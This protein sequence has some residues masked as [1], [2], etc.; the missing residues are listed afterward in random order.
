MSF[1]EIFA[2]VHCSFFAILFLF[3][4]SLCSFF[5]VMLT[6]W[7]I[8]CGCPFSTPCFLCSKGSVTK[9]SVMEQDW[10]RAI[11]FEWSQSRFQ[12]QNLK[13]SVALA[14]PKEG[15]KWKI[16]IVF[17]NLKRNFLLYFSFPL[18]YLTSLGWKN[19]LVLG[20][21]F[22]AYKFVCMKKYKCHFY[23]WSWSRSR[24]KMDRLRK[25]WAWKGDVISQPTW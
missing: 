15:K 8:P 4:Q 16:L 17:A 18:R 25:N 1:T 13:V 11:L 10:A 7:L 14:P 23:T 5:W 3:L 20:D 12:S 9:S 19:C 6:F 24:P 22:E 21:W 2:F